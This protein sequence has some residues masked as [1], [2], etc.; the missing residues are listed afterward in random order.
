MVGTAITTFTP[1]EKNEW[2]EISTLS[3]KLFD[4]KF[5]LNNVQVKLTPGID[6]NLIRV[7]FPVKFPTLDQQTHI[8]TCPGLVTL[9]CQGEHR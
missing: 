4:V 2:S 1:D 5:Q 8:I 7:C 9:I 6:I 3:T